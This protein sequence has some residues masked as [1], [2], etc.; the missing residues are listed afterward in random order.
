MVQFKMM[1]LCSAKPINYVVHQ[2]LELLPRLVSQAY[3]SERKWRGVPY[4]KAHFLQQQS[5][6]VLY[7]AGFTGVDVRE[8]VEGGSIPLKHTFCCSSLYLYCMGLVSQAWMS[9]RK[10]RGVP[11]L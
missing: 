1:S 9:E 4:L 6:P 2:M 8:E 3:M 11:Y 7:G 10:W 5:L